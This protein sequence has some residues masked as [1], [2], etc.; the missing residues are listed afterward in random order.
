MNIS[1]QDISQVVQDKNQVGG[2]D[3]SQR[4][5]RTMSMELR[6]TSDLPLGIDLSFSGI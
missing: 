5:P 3:E 6:M 2:N 1:K 4:T